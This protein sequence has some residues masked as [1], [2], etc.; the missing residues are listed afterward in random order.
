MATLSMW[1]SKLGRC[2]Y[3]IGHVLTALNWPVTHC[4]ASQVLHILVCQW[5]QTGPHWTGLFIV[6]CRRTYMQSL[7]TKAPG[8]STKHYHKVQACTGT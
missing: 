4:N 2:V 6:S 1:R 5:F 3:T 8:I 7:G